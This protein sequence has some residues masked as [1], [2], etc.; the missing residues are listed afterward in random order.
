MARY[1]SRELVHEAVEAMNADP[2][3]L[4]AA[5]LLSGKFALRALDAPDGKDVLVTYT[6]QAGKVT[7][8]DYESEPSAAG[9]LRQR[10][11]R[12]MKDGLARVTAAYATFVRLDRG[13]I[14]PAD[15]INSPDYKIEGP[16]LMLMPLMQAI[17]AWNRKV[18]GL[19]KEY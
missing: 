8:W 2:A 19:P 9:T 10:A 3:Y 1:F 4:A 17:D 5:K 12:P 6:F 7:G 15:A 13:E 14:D 18:R 11:F 16:M